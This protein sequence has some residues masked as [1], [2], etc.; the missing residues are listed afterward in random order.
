MKY[1]GEDI[2]YVGEGDGGN[3]Y[4]FMCPKCHNEL[5]VTEHPWDEVI[6]RCGIRWE[7]ILEVEGMK[8]REGR[9]NTSRAN[10]QRERQCEQNK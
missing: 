9:D 4:D 2:K 3:V 6:C 7:L 8:V 1:Y 5:H 10:T